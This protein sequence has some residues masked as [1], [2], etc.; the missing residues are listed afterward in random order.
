MVGDPGE[1]LRREGRRLL[2]VQQRFG[3]GVWKVTRVSDG[4][5]GGEGRRRLD[6][7]LLRRTELN[8]RYGTKAKK[9]RVSNAFVRSRKTQLHTF[10]PKRKK[11]TRGA[12][13]FIRKVMQGFQKADGCLTNQ[14]P[15]ISTRQTRQHFQLSL[16]IFNSLAA[17]IAF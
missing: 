13:I 16:F 15:G 1:R 5:L 9:K 6:G 7:G 8:S 17:R 12:E 3:G 11:R 14:D 10:R 4:F 2:V